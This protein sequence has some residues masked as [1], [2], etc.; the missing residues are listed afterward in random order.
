MSSLTFLLNKIFESQR[1]TK[2]TEYSSHKQTKSIHLWGHSQNAHSGWFQ[3]PGDGSS[4]PICLW[5]RNPGT[6]AIKAAPHNLIG[7]KPWSEAEAEIKTHIIPAPFF[8]LFPAMTWCSLRIVLPYQS[9]QI[10]KI[11]KWNFI[12][13]NI[14]GY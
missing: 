14:T 13:K 4:I 8:P 12:P 3:E 9:A 5:S 7:R 6:W 2:D 11:S 10:W 1:G